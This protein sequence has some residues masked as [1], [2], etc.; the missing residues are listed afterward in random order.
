MGFPLM[1]AVFKAS[2]AVVGFL[3]LSIPLLL[4]LGLVTLVLTALKYVIGWM[5]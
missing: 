5:N 1:K 2:I 3:V 4:I